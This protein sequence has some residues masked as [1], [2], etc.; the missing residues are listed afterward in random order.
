MSRMKRVRSYRDLLRFYGGRMLLIRRHLR[1]RRG[2]NIQGTVHHGPSTAR[3]REQA[4]V[5]FW[6]GAWA[7]W[8]RGLAWAGGGLLLA[9]LLAALGTLGWRGYR[10][11]RPAE[12]PPAPPAMALAPAVAPP[13]APAA[14]PPP[15]PPPEKP[16][17]PKPPA[18]LQSPPS[19]AAMPATITRLRMDDY[20]HLLQ[21]DNGRWKRAGYE[22]A[23]QR[24]L[25]F[26]KQK[27]WISALAAVRQALAGGWTD[28][29]AATAL[30]A[31]IQP[32]LGPPSGTPLRVMLNGHDWMEMAR[33][34]PGEFIMGSPE[35]EAGRDLDESRRRV[36]LTG[37][38]WMGRREVTQKEWLAIMHG[39]PSTYRGLDLPV[40]KVGGTE[41]HA[42][43]AELNRLAAAGRVDG[44]IE[45]G[46]VVTGGVFRLPTEAEWEYACRAGTGT[47]FAF[48]AVPDPRRA[49]FN[50]GGQ[51][52]A[53]RGP[54]PVGSFPPNAWGFFDMHG[55]V[56]ELCADWYDVYPEADLL[57]DPTGPAKGVYQVIRGGGWASLPADCRSAAR[58]WVV[59]G[60][61]GKAQ[62]L[63][64]VWQTRLPR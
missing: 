49:N 8:K 28:Q 47:P 58:L 43:L 63:R 22:A 37:G 1:G 14:P 15:K 9:A 41:V 33:L 4:P 44:F 31:R 34:A 54:L 5:S 52:A 64:L 12:A 23:L 45:G 27:D 51:A 21:S 19:G 40:E 13:N 26:E 56:W 60:H 38:C 29:E 17:E 7:A 18:A 32:R 53:D 57:T 25:E 61:A 36:R 59:T 35:T 39:N 50:S 46:G 11:A 20:P 10:W 16:P 48:G 2:S 24:A 3:G 42:F 62:G 30:L 6:R 55:N